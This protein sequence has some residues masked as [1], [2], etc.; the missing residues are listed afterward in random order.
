MAS[1]KWVL[2]ISIFL[3]GTWPAFAASG[4]FFS[5]Y[6]TDFVVLLAFITFVGVLLYYRVF[7]I[8][9][10]LLDKRSNVIRSELDNARKLREEAQ[11]LLASYERKQREVEEQSARIVAQAKFEAKEAAKKAEEDL[12]ASIARRIQA[13]DDKIVSAQA[14]AVREIRNRAIHI[15]IEAAAQAIST[16][17]N[18]K[19]ANALIEKSIEDLK[20][21]LD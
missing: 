17:L 5:L 19:E 10:G 4:P 15:A 1:L 13:A 16:S 2:Y 21:Q 11:D 20:N 3:S 8:V 18:K 6:N 12:K 9:G 14:R 7:H